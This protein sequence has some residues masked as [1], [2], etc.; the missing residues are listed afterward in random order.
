MKIRKHLK[1]AGFSLCA[2]LFFTAC[3][4][5]ADISSNSNE[6]GKATMRF[7]LTDAPAG[8]DAVYIDVQ[9]VRVHAATQDTAESGWITM[10]NVQPGIYNLLDFRNG[11]DTLI[12][13][14]DVPAGKISQIRLILGAQNSVVINGVSENLKTPSA[15]Q[16]GLKLQVN[17][18]LEPGLKYEFW[19]D[20]D[21]SR[22]IVERGNGDYNLKPVIRVYTASTTGSID[23]I[24]TPATAHS[25]VLAYNSAG[26]SAMAIGDTASGYFL[27]SGLTP[28]NYTVEF[29]PVAPFAPED[30][31]GIMVSAGMV[32]HL[33]SVRLN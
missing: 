16:S 27:I 21:A 6:R 28:D 1:L 4:D 8:Y 32:T 20:F 2:V 25:S 15:Q 18:R 7:N 31:T 11:L 10:D 5:D 9:E 26:D 24:I 19:I 17:Y 12:A 23:G 13:Y 3:S 22:S 29:D 14:G 30:T 33:D